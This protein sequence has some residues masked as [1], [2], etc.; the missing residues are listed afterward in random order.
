MNINAHT[1]QNVL[2]MTLSIL[3]KPNSS[4]N[5]FTGRSYLTY[6]MLFGRVNRNYLWLIL[7]KAGIPLDFVKFT[8]Q[9][10]TDTLLRI[11]HQGALGAYIQNNIGAPR[12]I[13]GSAQ[14]FIRYAAHSAKNYNGSLIIE[15]IEY[16]T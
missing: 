1:K 14:L 2:H 6:L 15:L 10:N 7:Y 16:T 8:V 3:A 5:K 13:P 4:T 9:G 12:G 11:K